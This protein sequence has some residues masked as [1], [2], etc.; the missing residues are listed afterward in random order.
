MDDNHWIFRRICKINVFARI[1]V[2]SGWDDGY[3]LYGIL[4]WEPGGLQDA[5]IAGTKLTG[6][7]T[8]ALSR[9]PLI[10]ADRWISSP[11]PPTA[12]ALCALCSTRN[13]V[14]PRGEI[15]PF[16]GFPT[17][18]VGSYITEGHLYISNSAL[19]ST[20]FESSTVWLFDLLK[21]QICWLPTS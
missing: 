3:F 15:D 17:G 4:R 6:S 1:D 19:R 16:L 14:I 18:S 11:S 5:S 20:S 9:H 10:Q 21:I 8:R 12:T 13:G 2:I 7:L